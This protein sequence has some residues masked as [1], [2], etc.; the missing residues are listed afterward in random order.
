MTQTLI[1]EISIIPIKADNG[2]IA[3]ADCVLD[4][5]YYLGGI[6]IYTRLN[7]P[8]FRLTYPTKTLKNNSQIPLFY[9]VSK[10][11]SQDIELAISNEVKKLLIPNSNP[12]ENLGGGDKNE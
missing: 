3:F 10:S 4:N 1:S 7:A 8:G 12:S 6:G 9:P 11:I 2:L 5:K